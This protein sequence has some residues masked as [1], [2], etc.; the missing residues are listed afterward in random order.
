MQRA[1]EFLPA[2]VEQQVEPFIGCDFVVKAALRTDVGVGF[3]VLFPDRLP[4][5]FALHP[6]AFG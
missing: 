5:A 6:K 2:F 1:V 3:Q 4:A